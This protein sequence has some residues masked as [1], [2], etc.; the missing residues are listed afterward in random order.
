[1]PDAR[2]LP[3]APPFAGALPPPWTDPPSGERR[4]AGRDGAADEAPRSDADAGTDP[5]VERMIRRTMDSPD[6]P[7]DFDFDPPDDQGTTTDADNWR[8]YF[9]WEE[10]DDKK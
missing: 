6:D 4:S 7:D 8:D 10:D 2:C 1:M 3:W 9:T 5:E